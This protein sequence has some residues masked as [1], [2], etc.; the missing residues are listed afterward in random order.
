ML[1]FKDWHWL[2]LN[3]QLI[4]NEEWQVIAILACREGLEQNNIYFCSPFTI[5]SKVV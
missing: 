2:I 4:F 1:Q 3:R 5:H